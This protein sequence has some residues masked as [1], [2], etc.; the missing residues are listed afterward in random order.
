MISRKL[1]MEEVC[2]NVSVI[3][4][5]TNGFNSPIKEIL[6][7]WIKKRK[8]SYM[9]LTKDTLKQNTEKLNIK[10]ILKGRNS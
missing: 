3:T 5:N 2:S 1:K 7:T 9:L 4:I 8:S 10:G 6:S